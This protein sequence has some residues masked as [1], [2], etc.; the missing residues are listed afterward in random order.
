MS[1]TRKKPRRGTRWRSNGYN[2]VADILKIREKFGHPPCR[3]LRD[4]SEEEILELERIYEC[5]VIRP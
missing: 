5:K 3:T 1:A 2:V 4:M